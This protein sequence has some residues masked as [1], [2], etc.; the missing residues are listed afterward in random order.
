MIVGSGQLSANFYNFVHGGT[1]AL[2]TYV[3]WQH[4]GCD[5]PS[6]QSLQKEERAVY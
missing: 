4:P 5:S 6:R 2:Y 3:R 1:V